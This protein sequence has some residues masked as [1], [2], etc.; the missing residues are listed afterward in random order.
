MSVICGVK[1]GRAVAG[2]PARLVC[3]VYTLVHRLALRGKGKSDGVAAPV[4]CGSVACKPS[5]RTLISLAA[6]V[7]GRVGKNCVKLCAVVD[8]GVRL[9]KRDYLVRCGVALDEALDV[10][11]LILAVHADHRKCRGKYR[12]AL[13]HLACKGASAREHNEALRAV[14]RGVEGVSYKVE[15]IVSLRSVKCKGS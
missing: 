13:I 8:R 2:V 9:D 1:I 6:A 15:L 5:V 7:N 10:G 12:R 4:L 14:D 3:T 11:V